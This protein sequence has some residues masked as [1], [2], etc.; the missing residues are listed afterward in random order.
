MSA[1]HRP[2][3]LMPRNA[4]VLQARSARAAIFKDRRAPRGGSRDWGRQW[5]DEL[6]DEPESCEPPPSTTEH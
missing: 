4:F 2:G 1:S 5:L 3:P 6:S